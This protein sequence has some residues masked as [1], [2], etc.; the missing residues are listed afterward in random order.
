MDAAV[1]FRADREHA[2]VPPLTDFDMAP[3][4]HGWTARPPGIE[5]LD[6]EPGEDVAEAALLEGLNVAG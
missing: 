3:V 5:V 2:R 6:V 1:P 4:V